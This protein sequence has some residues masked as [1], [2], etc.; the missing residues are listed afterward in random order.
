MKKWLTVFVICS[1]FFLGCTKQIIVREESVH[2]HKLRKG[3]VYTV[4]MDGWFLSNEAI[5]EMLEKYEN[6]KAE[7]EKCR[8]EKDK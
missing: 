3:E 8:L 6:L 5:I 4:T 2:A 7:L 1:C